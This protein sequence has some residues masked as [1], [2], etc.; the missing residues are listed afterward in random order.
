MKFIH[1]KKWYRNTKN[2]VTDFFLNYC[3]SDKVY[4]KF[5]YKQVF[6]RKLDFKNP[7]SFNEKIQWLKMYD[8]NPEYHKMV[9]KYTAK[10]YVAGIIGEEYI[11]PTYGAWDRFE[12]IDFDQLPDQFVLKCNHDAASTVL[13]KDK[14][15][16][17]YT[18]AKKKLNKAVKQ[19]YYRYQNR[20]WAYKGVKRKIMAEKYMVD[21]GRE[22]LEDYKFLV[23]NNKVKC[24]FVCTDRYSGNGLKITFFDENWEKLPFERHYKTEDSLPKPP[25]YDKMVELSEKIA[26][27]VGAP[28]VRIDF[29]D[30]L[31]KIYFG[32]ITFYPGGGTE[33]F[34]PDS[35]DYE[36]GSWIKL[37]GLK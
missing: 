7:L 14:K 10:D 24:S 18:A 23:F 25:N 29:Y 22:E 37:P 34:T 30:I 28:F 26:E 6:G 1:P 15:T 13:C 2:Y 20:Q 21:S 5:R 36:L 35:W 3:L 4:L 9:D 32:E 31:N 17:D 8:R 12:D 11:I 33:E 16:F 19:D 27:K